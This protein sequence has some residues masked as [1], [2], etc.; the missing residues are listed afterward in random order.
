M[1]SGKVYGLYDPRN[2]EIRY[3]G[4]TV[5]SLKDRLQRHVALARAG[6]VKRHVAQWVASLL[7]E[8]LYPDIRQLATATTHEELNAIEVRLISDYRKVGTSLT[9]HAEGGLGRPG[10]TLSE[11]HRKKLH[12]PTVWAKISETKKGRPSTFK[13]KRHSAE[14]I[15]KIERHRKGKTAGKNHPNYRKDVK[16]SDILSYMEQGY[17]TSRIGDLLNVDRHTIVKRVKD[18]R[19]RGVSTPYL[20][21]ELPIQLILEGLKSGLSRK[22]VAEEL[23]VSLSTVHYRLRGRQNG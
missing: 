12:N 8:G 20:R 22:E 21:G 16:D 4:Q 19:A 15:K 9:N 23:G 6:K 10:V 1:I 18:M 11:E 14:A 17:S 3:V 2:G 13:G 7:A 5:R